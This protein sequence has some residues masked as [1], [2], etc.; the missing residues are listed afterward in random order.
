MMKNHI[1][2]PI[3]YSPPPYC[4]GGE[5]DTIS[6]AKAKRRLR[7]SVKCINFAQLFQERIDLRRKFRAAVHCV[8][9]TN[10]W[11]QRIYLRRKFQATIH[12]IVYS[13]KLVNRSL[14][15]TFD[16]GTFQDAVHLIAAVN[17]LQQESPMIPKYHTNDPNREYHDGDT[18]RSGLNKLADTVERVRH[19]DVPS[20]NHRN[21]PIMLR[22]GLHKL[23]RVV[24]AVR[25]GHLTSPLSTKQKSLQSG[26]AEVA[27]TLRHDRE[28]AM[29]KAEY[30]L[31]A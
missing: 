2:R 3:H 29:P 9:L 23:A 25:H 27:E 4:G 30:S 31:K 7:A 14:G 10:S 28:A 15:G 26:M 5:L 19:G 16:L 24:E 1:P 12:T 6:R 17:R 18:L 13:E 8:K 20:D 11:K 21:D 22:A